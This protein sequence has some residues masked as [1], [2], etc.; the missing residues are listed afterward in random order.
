MAHSPIRTRAGLPRLEV[1]RS[2]NRIRLHWTP[3]RIRTGRS[4]MTPAGTR[5]G[6]T[7]IGHPGCRKLERHRF[8]AVRDRATQ[9]R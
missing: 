2:A 1:A 9:P 7:T 4:R 5:S 6:P 8:T 3:S